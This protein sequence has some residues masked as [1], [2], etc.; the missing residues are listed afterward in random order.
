MRYKNILNRVVHAYAVAAESMSPINYLFGTGGVIKAR[1]VEITFSNALG[2]Y[3][4]PAN[5]ISKCD[6]FHA[7]TG[8]QHAI[9]DVLWNG[10]TCTPST[11]C[12]NNTVGSDADKGRCRN[13]YTDGRVVPGLW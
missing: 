10:L 8:A 11:P 12:C 2:R 5:M 3:K 7:N 1:G 9:A 4:F 6:C 13:V